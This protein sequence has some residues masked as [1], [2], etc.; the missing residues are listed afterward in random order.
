MNENKVNVLPNTCYPCYAKAIPVAF[1]ES[2]TYL[3]QVSRLLYKINELIPVVNLNSENI[4][5]LKEYVDNYFKNLDVQDEINNKLDQMVE[6]GTLEKIINEGILKDLYNKLD[7]AVKGLN[8]TGNFHLFGITSYPSQE[9]SITQGGCYIGDNKI[10]YIQNKEDNDG[11]IRIANF[12][13]G[14]IEKSVLHNDM[15]HGQS[16]CKNNNYL[17][18]TGYNEKKLIVVDIETLETVNNIELTFFPLGITYKDGKY[19]VSEK[20]TQNVHVLNE[21]F[22]EERVFEI[23]YL[24]KNAKGIH[25]IDFNGESLMCL[26]NYQVFEI[27]IE[28]GETKNYLLIDKNVDNN[29]TMSEIEFF[30]YFEKDKFLIGSIVY[31]SLI[32]RGFGGLNTMFTYYNPEENYKL[33]N[34]TILGWENKQKDV[35]VDNTNVNYYRDGSKNYPF[36]NVYEAINSLN[37]GNYKYGSITLEDTYSENRPIIIIGSNTELIEIRCNNKTISGFFVDYNV[38]LT[39]SGNPQISG[40]DL[41]IYQDGQDK[42]LMMVKHN[43]VVNAFSYT[44]L[45]NL[46]LYIQLG[47]KVKIPPF[48]KWDIEK[49]FNEGEIFFRSILETDVINPS[50]DNLGCII[51]ASSTYTNT[52]G[53]S[54]V[55]L[56][57]PINGG[58]IYVT[59]KD[60]TRD[61]IDVSNGSMTNGSATG[62]KTTQNSHLN[63]VNISLTSTKPI[64][65][66][67]WIS[68]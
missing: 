12:K 6:D 65:F 53:F 52:S 48:S 29:L 25:D 9:Y 35:Y 60:G 4:I 36:I 2:L 50:N 19:Y 30:T 13:T 8:K 37:A 56:K 16:M 59:Y 26:N 33:T 63:R 32:N 38:N 46:S 62:L 18:I 14:L 61:N 21:E 67:R 44:I 3:E 39:I 68:K 20:S 34:S 58:V 7:Q 45:D 42:C 57:M 43:S 23:K 11:Y 40:V 28:N 51:N 5:K 41:S 64:S 55:D 66:V 31:P 22:V 15:S 54:N 27:D 24:N 47:S 10:A 49:T 1:D 17:I